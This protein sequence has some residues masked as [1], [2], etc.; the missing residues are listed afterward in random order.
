MLTHLSANGKTVN[1]IANFFLYK[2]ILNRHL[3]FRIR[4]G[5]TSAD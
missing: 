4:G 1:E 2:I 5:E 3:A